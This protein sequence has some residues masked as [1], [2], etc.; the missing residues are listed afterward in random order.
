MSAIDEPLLLMSSTANW[1]DDIVDALGAGR[2]VVA[3]VPPGATEDDFRLIADAAESGHAVFA[4]AFGELRR[5]Q[6]AAMRD[7]VR[8]GRIGLPWNAQVT[9]VGSAPHGLWAAAVPLVDAV[10]ELMGLPIRRL[11]AHEGSTLVLAIDHE[12]GASSTVSVSA[13]ETPLV[14]AYRVSG[15]SGLLVA[16]GLRPAVTVR[17]GDRVEAVWD[18]PSTD[19]ALRREFAA[20]VAGGRPQIERAR[21]ASM[22]V[23]AAMR[24]AQQRQP[25]EVEKGAAW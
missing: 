2:S 9:V 17:V 19:E 20:T 7:A 10:L 4:P 24:S 23:G 25:V 11:R 3:A 8:A 14:H 18:G 13:A 12:R 22:I 16:D 1:P 21:R 5:P 6:L 15:S